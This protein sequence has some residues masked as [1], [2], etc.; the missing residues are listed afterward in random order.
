MAPFAGVWTAL[1]SVDNTQ[2]KRAS[3]TTTVTH[4]TTL[5]NFIICKTGDDFLPSRR[6]IIGRS[7][8]MQSTM[9]R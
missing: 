5:L 7:L 9:S 1:L 8:T 3:I 6:T 2:R 4:L